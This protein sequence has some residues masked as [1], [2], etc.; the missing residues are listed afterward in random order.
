MGSVRGGFE[1]QWEHTYR[2][3]ELV[4]VHGISLMPR[5]IEGWVCYFGGFCTLH[6][7]HRTRGANLFRSYCSVTEKAQL[8][9]SLAVE[10]RGL[11]WKASS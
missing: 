11:E 2:L 6:R 8:T 4:T 3:K 7:F 9:L 10:S 1:G 5:V